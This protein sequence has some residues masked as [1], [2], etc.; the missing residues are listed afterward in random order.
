MFNLFS[1]E[2][3]KINL[4]SFFRRVL[5]FSQILKIS[6]ANRVITADENAVTIIN[7]E[8]G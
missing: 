6:Q 1:I 8:I 2:L 7:Y 4:F 5:D 3:V